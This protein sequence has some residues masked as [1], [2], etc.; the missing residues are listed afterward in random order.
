MNKLN[1]N[2][3]MGFIFSCFIATAVSQENN[4]P[5]A[6]ERRN[7]RPTLDQ[8]FKDLDLNED[9]KIAVEEARGPLK[10]NFDKIDLDKDGFIT[11]EEFEKAPKPERREQKDRN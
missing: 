9:S 8:I 4:R 5:E 6:G 10:K 11:R 3:I 7:Q 1:C 2:L